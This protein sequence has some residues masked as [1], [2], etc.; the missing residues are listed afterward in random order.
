LRRNHD[1]FDN[2]FFKRDFNSFSKPRGIWR[3]HGFIFSKLG[4]ISIALFVGLLFFGGCAVYKN[5]EKTVTFT[6]E[7]KEHITD[8]SGTGESTSCDSYY[9]VFTDQGVFKND[10]DIAYGKFRSSDL[11]GRFKKGRT[12]TCKVAGWRV[13]ILSMYPNIID[14]ER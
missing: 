3:V 1:P 7:D 13:G 9:L 6:V 2:E 12:F 11:Q 8:C 4:L 10:D 14:C 5:S